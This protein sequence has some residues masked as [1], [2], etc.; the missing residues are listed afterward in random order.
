[1]N[2]LKLT[3]CPRD[4]MQGL[5]DFIPTEIKIDYINDILKCGFDT[6]DSLSLSGAT[7]DNT[8]T[9]AELALA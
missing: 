7:D 2:D 8:P 4:A 6:V 3:E 1:M 9:T 5:H